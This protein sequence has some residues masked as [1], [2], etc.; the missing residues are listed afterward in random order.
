MQ[1][2]EFVTRFESLSD[3]AFLA[4]FGHPFLLETGPVLE[5]GT[6][7]AKRLVFLLR[8]RGGHGLTIG[9]TASCDV[10]LPVENVS[11]RHAVLLPPQGEGQAWSVLDTRSTNGTYLEGTRLQ[12]GVPAEVID[13]AALRFGPDYRFTFLQSESFLSRLRLLAK[14]LPRG[15]GEE[16]Y[17]GQ[18]D[19]NLV[20]QLRDSGEGPPPGEEPAEILLH[21]DAPDSDSVPLRVGDK[22]VVGRTPK[23]A[24]FV[25]PHKNVSRAHAE[26]E[27][28]ANGIF[29]RDLGSSNGTFIGAT[30]VGPRWLELLVNK[31]VAIGPYTLH[32]S[33]PQ[34][35]LTRTTVVETPRPTPREGSLDQTPARDILSEVEMSQLT[36]VLRLEAGS[37]RGVISFRAG[38]PHDAQTK[39]GLKGLTALQA[40]FGLQHGKYWLDL[41]TPLEDHPR[42]IQRTFAEVA[43]EAFFD[44]ASP[45]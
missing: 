14:N 40:L 6:T 39:D 18:T 12:A 2:R 33:G 19:P 38:E 17:L 42:T 27:R 13:A 34:E 24:G 10:Q 15:S 8:P 29:I 37:L 20:A 3:E 16:A 22:V 36:G 31:N 5:S 30:R 35:A 7:Q 26:L 21:S 1:L 11:S 32:V 41:D 9:R 45:S 4:N 23:N 44:G 28:R 25:L 43:L